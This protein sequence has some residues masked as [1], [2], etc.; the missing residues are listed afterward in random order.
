MS[1]ESKTEPTTAENLWHCFAVV[2]KAGDEATAM[3]DEIENKLW[4]ED[5]EGFIHEYGKRIH[6]D[7]VEGEEREWVCLSETRNFFFKPD[8]QG[9]KKADSILAVQVVFYSKEESKTGEQSVINVMYGSTDEYDVF[10]KNYF[11]G[12][13]VEKGDWKDA[14]LACGGRLVWFGDDNEVVEWAFSYPLHAI[15]NPECIDTKII[16]PIKKLLSGTHP[17]K[18]QEDLLKD[19]L[20]FVGEGADIK[21]AD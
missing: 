17:E 3:L 5:S 4:A 2:A 18:M 16:E 14:K 8:G 9:N 6:A 10:K 21:V 12:G 13:D 1:Q 7:K 19:A 15:E 11:G 20:R